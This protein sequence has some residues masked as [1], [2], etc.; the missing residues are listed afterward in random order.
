MGAG[1]R[2][3][4]SPI[5]LDERNS[6]TDR[7]MHSLPYTDVSDQFGGRLPSFFVQVGAAVLGFWSNECLNSAARADW[8]LTVL[9]A[10]IFNSIIFANIP[11]ATPSF[12]F[13]LASEA[14]FSARAP[15]D[16]INVFV[17]VLSLC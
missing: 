10:T 9:L 6:L 13:I 8:S 12:S 14:F 5:T 3:D 2:G 15:T 1:D 7:Q 11:S 16:R 17:A 4:V